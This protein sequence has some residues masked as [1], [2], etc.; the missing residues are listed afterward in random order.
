MIQ[1]NVH[2]F[3]KNKQQ[4]IIYLHDNIECTL[5]INGG[6]FKNNQNNHYFGGLIWSYGTV[7]IAGG[8]FESNSANTSGGVLCAY[9]GKVT[10]SGGTFT[11]NKAQ[12]GGAILIGGGAS[13]DIDGT[14]NNIKFTENQAKYHGGAIDF[15]QGKKT[16]GAM[17]INNA[18]FIKN[19]ANMG[20]ALYINGATASLT[21]GTYKRNTATNSGGGLYAKNAEVTLNG[22]FY[23][24]NKALVN[25]GSIYTEGGK[26][27]VG[28]NAIIKNNQS[29]GYGGGVCLAF[30]EASIKNSDVKENKASVGGGVFIYS[31]RGSIESTNIESNVAEKDPNGENTRIG[32]GVLALEGPNKGV[33]VTLNKCA[34]KTNQAFCGAGVTVGKGTVTIEGTEFNGNTTGDGDDQ[35]K[36]LGGGIYIDEESLAKISGKSKFLNNVAGVGG[37]IF[38]ASCDYSNPADETKY[39]NLTIENT[40]LFKG[41]KAKT[42]ISNPMSNFKKFAN[43]QFDS[44]SD[45]KHGDLT[46]E[47][48]L[49]NYD[50]NYKNPSILIIYKANGG[51]FQD[52]TDIKTEEHNVGERITIIQPPTQEGYIF[53]HWKGSMYQPGDSYTVNENHTFIAQW[54]K[55]PYHHFDQRNEKIRIQVTKI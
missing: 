16:K 19:Q 7:N 31:G 18:T 35:N 46:R 36:R 47:S 45:I 4:S 8:V 38:D 48:L 21:A 14:K 22:C 26:V 17:N 30:S 52:G 1:N 13:L 34:I 15:M 10:I 9:S 6:I 44:Q 20:G 42:G 40:V 28:N 12:W 43:L 29:G 54:K 32:G 5:N 53:D 11:K 49:N 23:M 27:E 3:S 37:A 24:E 51:M 25:G 33:E 55:K 50:V 41:N 2:N 39:Q